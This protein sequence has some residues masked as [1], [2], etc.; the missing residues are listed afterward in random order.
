MEGLP[1]HAWR[2]VASLKN[3]ERLDQLMEGWFCL[4]KRASLWRLCGQG[5]AGWD[6]SVAGLGLR[7]SLPSA[8]AQVGSSPDGHLH[9]GIKCFA[10]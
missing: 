4:P 6:W 1:C 3:E 10:C 8:C 5:E 9:L 7:P 2:Q